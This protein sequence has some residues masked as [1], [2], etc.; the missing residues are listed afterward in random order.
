MN[1][2]ARLTT[3][4]Q[5]LPSERARGLRITLHGAD[6]DVERDIVLRP[7]DRPSAPTERYDSPA[8]F[9]ERYPAGEILQHLVLS[10]DTPQ[11]RHMVL[12]EWFD[13][14]ER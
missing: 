4:E 11:E 12:A 3:L 9:Y 8:A 2:I 1:T 14:V 13:K 7:G 6:D 5:R 10:Y